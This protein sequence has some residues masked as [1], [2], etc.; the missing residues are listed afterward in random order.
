MHEIDCFCIPR[1]WAAHFS[2]LLD[3]NH[4]RL[5]YNRLTKSSPPFAHCL[6]SIPAMAVSGGTFVNP[7][8]EPPVFPSPSFLSD[9]ASAF[10]VS[11]AEGSS[12]EC[13]VASFSILLTSSF[14]KVL[15][16]G[17]PSSLLISSRVKNWAS[18][19]QL[20]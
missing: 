3:Y 14:E 16:V 9:G 7:V 2:D 20:G 17:D 5:P 8:P 1:R 6:I 11:S 13:E 19:D 10:E 15:P 12:C 18:D 4:P